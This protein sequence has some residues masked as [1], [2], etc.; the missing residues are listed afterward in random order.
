MR[1][2]AVFLL[3]TASL[4]ATV[5]CA[6]GGAAV[7]QPRA[8]AAAAAAR[9]P[10]SA[11]TRAGIR[12]PQDVEGC[13]TSGSA[14]FVG[15]G[16]GNV[17]GGLDSGVLEGS[18]NNACAEYTAIGGGEYNTIDSSS[19]YSLVAG[20]YNNQMS[21]QYAFI[22][23]G[24]DNTVSGLS[25]VISG[26]SANNVP[27]SH[28]FVGGGQSNS[29]ASGADFGSI[30]GGENNTVSS[31]W[32]VIGG[33]YRNSASGTGYAFIGAGL[34][35][36]AS[37]EGAV[38]TGGYG[39]KASAAWATIPG[40]YV[41]TASGTF[42]FAAGGRAQA[43]HTGA[44]VWS[45]G[46]DGDG[47]LKS[48]AAYQFLARAAGGVTFWSNSAATVGVKLAPGSGT[49]ASLSDRA[50]KADVARIDESGVLLKLAAL[51]IST[52]SYVSERGVRH[53]GPM[54]QDFYAAFGVGEDDRH[55]T[56]I[57]ENGV[58]LAAIKAVHRENLRL[59]A[60]LA[61]SRAADARQYRSLAS[62]IRRLRVVLEQ[63]RTR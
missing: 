5:A 30:A 11:A 47:L 37:G 20:G 4:A 40:G 50:S 14:S 3:L 45:D 16:A 43:L 49:W 22:G 2:F 18:S 1:S 35:N 13:T 53:V 31:E 57:D 6:S 17:A 8:E 46:S 61:A 23:G 55:I 51:P 27:A 21:A 59:R 56:A 58:A 62:E 9:V 36:A 24:G 34:A 33:G 48:T 32:G 42:S 12:R 60:Q 7:T 28:G 25:S 15:G 10:G 39:N 52:W 44:F 19:N 38:V 54:A 29:V 63:L 41:N 26:G